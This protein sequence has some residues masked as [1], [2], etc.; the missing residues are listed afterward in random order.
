MI[1][2]RAEFEAWREAELDAVVYEAERA[3][4]ESE[5]LYGRAEILEAMT[6]EEWLAD[7]AFDRR[8][9]VREARQ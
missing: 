3:A 5:R 2:S 6:Y 1:A 8:K 9:A 7:A 4:A